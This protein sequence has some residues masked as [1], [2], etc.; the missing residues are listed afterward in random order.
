MALDTA[1][2]QRALEAFQSLDLD[3]KGVMRKTDLVGVFEQ[4]T[5]DKAALSLISE[6]PHDSVNYSALIRWLFDCSPSSFAVF[7]SFEVKHEFLDAFHEI[8]KLDAAETRKEAGCLRFDLL[9]VEGSVTK[10]CLYEAYI[11]EPAA[12]EHAKTS[13][14]MAWNE[15]KTTKGGVIEGSYN[16]L[17]L[18]PLQFQLSANV[19]SLAPNLTPYVVLVTF[20]VR[21]ELLKEFHEIMAV[22]ASQTRKESGCLRFD[23]FQVQGTETKFCLYEAYVNEAAAKEHAQT[24]HYKMWNVFKTSKG[25][26]VEGS[27]NKVIANSLD[28]HG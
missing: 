3:G 18:N 22:D 10:F 2:R 11:D 15:F 6:I 16:K 8:M 21:N 17:I 28:F 27:Y 12:K 1:S 5:T 4:L 13:H 20:E 26:V 9:Q 7:V 24:D 19:A 14:Y 25:G 23:L